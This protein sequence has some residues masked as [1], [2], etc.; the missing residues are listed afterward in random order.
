[1]L[2]LERILAIPEFD[3]DHVQMGLSNNTWAVVKATGKTKDGSPA[4]ASV[5][6]QVRKGVSQQDIEKAAKG[7]IKG[8]KKLEDASKVS[9]I[10]ERI[11]A[12]ADQM[13]REKYNIPADVSVKDFLAKKE[14]ERQKPVKKKDYY[15]VESKDYSKASDY[16]L[17]RIQALKDSGSATVN[18]LEKNKTS[19][20][21]VE[22]VHIRKRK[23]KS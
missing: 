17:A 21:E 22:S 2:V 23:K 1:M 20:A 9:S 14:G 5:L 12:K 11:R 18:A 3:I 15:D 7:V 8:D 16:H 4:K 6:K 13:Q 10:A 19:I